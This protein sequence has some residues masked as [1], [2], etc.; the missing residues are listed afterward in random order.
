MQDCPMGKRLDDK[1]DCKRCGTISLE[2]PE[3]ATEDT[4]IH[5][6]SCGALM[7]TWGELQDDFHKQARGGGVFDLDDG[8]IEE[9]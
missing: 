8:N 3:D 2:I 6:S 4:L 7:G 9:H 1:L 5:C